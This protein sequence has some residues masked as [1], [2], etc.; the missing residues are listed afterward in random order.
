[1]S[2]FILLFTSHHGEKRGRGSVPRDMKAIGATW[3]GESRVALP[4]DTDRGLGHEEVILYFKPP[5]ASI[6]TISCRA[7]CGLRLSVIF[8]PAS[9]LTYDLRLVSLIVS[10][11]HC[12]HVRPYCLS[13]LEPRYSSCILAAF[14]CIS[15]GGF[16]IH[17]HS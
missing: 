14:Y 5:L 9:R 15:T 16:S 4:P 13:D 12:H 11:L 10:A 17:L 3:Q 1:M 6:G 8:G 2:M 7:S